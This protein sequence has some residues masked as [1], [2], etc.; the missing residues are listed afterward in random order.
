MFEEILNTIENEDLK[1][2]AQEMIKTIPDY[3]YHV[4]A[5]S[6]GKY[7]PDYCLGEGGLYRHTIALC[8]ILNHILTVSKYS[9]R[10]KDLMR[11]AGIMHDTRKSGT[12]EQYKENKFTKFDHPLLS[13]AVVRSFK[14]KDWNDEE[15]EIIANAIESHMGQ[16]NTDKRS[17]VVLPL[18]ENKY[19]MLVNWADY[20]ASRK[21]IEVKF[22]Y[23]IAEVD[24]V[25]PFG[26][27]KGVKIVDLPLDYCQWCV[28]NMTHLRE[29][30][31]L[32]IKDRL[33]KDG[34]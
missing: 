4:P 25:M 6:T 7:H 9:S 21:D 18:P 10:D 31:M 5:S 15:I 17:D 3:F 16:W 13:A 32:A 20:I 8:R 14:G 22:N 24:P 2:L 26:K 23:Q 12:Q 29:P 19:Q 34:V 28:D 30:L 11:I 33:K 1:E 27:Y